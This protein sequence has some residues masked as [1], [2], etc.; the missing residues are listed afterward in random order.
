MPKQMVKVEGSRPGKLDRQRQ[1]QRLV[2]MLIANNFLHLNRFLLDMSS[3]RV[4]EPRAWGSSLPQ[5]GEES[6][7]RVQCSESQILE[8]LGDPWTER[9]IAKRTDVSDR[10]NFKSRKVLPRP[11]QF[12]TLTRCIAFGNRQTSTEFAYCTPSN[13]ETASGPSSSTE[14]TRICEVQLPNIV[15]LVAKKGNFYVAS[16]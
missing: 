12:A 6:R 7:E 10:L 11:D 14:H 1:Y 16:V 3:L 15:A 9:L 2:A 4:C 13:V 5:R 8:P